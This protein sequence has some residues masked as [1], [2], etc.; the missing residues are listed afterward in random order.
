MKII[1][2]SIFFTTFFL[3]SVNKA[4]AYGN[5]YSYIGPVRCDWSFEK[6]DK[7]KFNPIL[8]LTV[9]TGNRYMTTFDFGF[10]V[11]SMVLKMFAGFIIAH[12]G[13]YIGGKLAAYGFSTGSFE[14][15]DIGMRILGTSEWAAG[16]LTG[17]LLQSLPIVGAF[18][19]LQ[20]ALSWE[21]PKELGP[22]EANVKIYVD[23]KYFSEKSI[24][25]GKLPAS[26]KIPFILDDMS[27]HII[28]AN[29]M[30]TGGEKVYENEH[31]G[32]SKETNF[33]TCELEW[34]QAHLGSLEKEE[35]CK[36]V[37][38]H[39]EGNWINSQQMQVNVTSSPYCSGYTAQIIG[40]G[41][42]LGTLDNEGK[43]TFV[44]GGCKD[45][46]EVYVELP[47]PGIKSNSIRIIYPEQYLTDQPREGDE[48]RVNPRE[49]SLLYRFTQPNY[50]EYC[51]DE[52]KINGILIGVPGDYNPKS[53]VGVLGVRV[54]V[55]DKGKI[56]CEG[57]SDVAGSIS[58]KPFQCF[59]RIVVDSGMNY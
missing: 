36:A 46:A 12:A 34:D 57:Y 4:N 22:I 41:Y 45:G 16:S 35:L 51:L 15:W 54:S 48:L 23:G 39:I 31:T 32:F 43:I 20:D 37:G 2:F 52:S 10:R 38:L 50:P 30:R 24:Y 47:Y 27:K 53:I 56:V 7:D 21:P 40:C 1:V 19:D 6:I 58:C 42:G 14:T 25:L 11:T 26:M 8:K 29:V 5:P 59:D 28:R 9:G 33:W 17:V 3:I 18:Y 44:V 49:G 13:L 55:Y